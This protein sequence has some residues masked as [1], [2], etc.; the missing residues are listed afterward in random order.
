MAA[1]WHTTKTVT[2]TQIRRMK[3]MFGLTTIKGLSK[4]AGLKQRLTVFVIAAFISLLA[5]PAQAQ[6]QTGDYIF[7]SGNTVELSVGL[8]KGQTLRLRF[9]ETGELRSSG[10]PIVIVTGAGG[11]VGHVKVFSGSSGALLQSHDL[12]GLTIGLHT[13]D[14]NRNDLHEE[15][16]P[17]TGRIQLRIEVVIDPCSANRQ[18]TEECEV[19]MFAPYFEVVDNASDRTTVHLTLRKVARGSLGLADWWPTK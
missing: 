7:L 6:A 2:E 17:G 9:A 18:G 5:L 1:A 3:L 13:I 15:G 4:R 16:E 8:A 19:W 11:P 14:I 12:T 10:E